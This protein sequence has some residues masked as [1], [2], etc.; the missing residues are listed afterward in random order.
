VLAKIQGLTG[1]KSNLAITENLLMRS[2]SD[3]IHLIATDLESGFEGF[4][5]AQIQEEGTV[6]INAKT[7]YEIVRELPTE[8]IRVH[9]VENRWIEIGNRKVLYHI[10]GMNPEDY[11]DHPTVSDVAFIEF[12]G[13]ALKKMIE[14][15]VMIA[16]APNDKRAH[17]NGILFEKRAEGEQNVLRMVSTD[18]SRLTLADHILEAAPDAFPDDGLIVP[19]RGLN[20]VGK[21]LDGEEKIRIGT[22]DNKF[23]VKKENETFIIRLLEGDFPKY[24]DIIDRERGHQIKLERLV[25]LKMLKRMSILSSETYKGVIFNFREN[26]LEITATNPDRGESKEDMDI[27]Y[28]GDPMQIAFNP[29]Y[30]IDVLNVMEE[31]TVLLHIADEEKPC[32]ID[33]ETDKGFLSVIMPMRI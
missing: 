24:A 20:E 15:T 29:R 6:A 4:Y 30:F 27:E 16:G 11:P 31:D 21:F 17:I 22:K 7:F 12:P 1:R 18:G 25:F 3:G 33:G 19:K 5:P 26:N 14:K 10:V 2:G 23:I 28:G 8:E 9:E 32:L 13:D